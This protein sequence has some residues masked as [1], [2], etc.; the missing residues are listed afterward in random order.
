MSD[1][2][3]RGHEK[4]LSDYGRSMHAVTL[5]HHHHGGSHVKFKCLKQFT[6]AKLKITHFIYNAMVY[7]Q[8]ENIFIVLLLFLTL[9][10]IRVFNID[11]NYLRG[12]NLKRSRSNL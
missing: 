6:Y 7:V 10:V 4:Q 9:N 5:T 1:R 8:N 11:S 2:W 3:M 12:T